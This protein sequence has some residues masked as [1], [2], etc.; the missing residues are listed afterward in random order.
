MKTALAT[1]SGTPKLAIVFGSSWFDQTQL[2]RGV[3]TALGA[4]PIIGESTAGEIVSTGPKTHSCVVLLI[5][6]NSVS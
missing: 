6:S 5:A 1:L 3:R 4:I 2:L